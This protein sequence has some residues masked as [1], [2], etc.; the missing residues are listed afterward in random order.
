[1]NELLENTLSNGVC[2]TCDRDRSNVYHH[3]HKVG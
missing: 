2:R 3:E 1:M